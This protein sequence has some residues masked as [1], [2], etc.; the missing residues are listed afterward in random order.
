M[1]IASLLPAA[2]LRD[3]AEPAHIAAL[4]RGFSVEATRPSAGEIEALREAAP[5][6][7]HV[8]VSAVATRPLHDSIFAAAALRRAGFEP[9]PHV[10]V[11]N[12]SG[13]EALDDFLARLADEAGVR[14][15]LVIAGDRDQP[16]GS[17]HAAIEAIDSG[18]LGRRGIREIGIAGYPDGHPRVPQLDLDR[19]LVA[20]IEAAEQTGLAVHVVT[21]FCFAAAPILHFLGRLRDLGI[22][23]PVRVGLAGPTS[24]AGLLRYA[25]RCGVKASAQGLTRQAGLARH[26][27]GMAA[28]DAIVRSLAGACADGALGDVALHFFAFGGAA[29]TARWAGAA[30]AGRIAIEGGE[31][32]RVEAP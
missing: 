2:P 25:Q 14:R 11:R 20:K 29:M 26:L 7:T 23:H 6:G 9:V 4:M 21:Q 18:L 28:P 3:G 12:F 16:A 19:A 22:D 30:A 5:A 15:V 13:V 10:A 32:F 17:L 1:T 8:Y 24:L 31:G 27:F